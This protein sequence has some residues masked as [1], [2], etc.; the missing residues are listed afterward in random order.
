MAPKIRVNLRL[1]TIELVDKIIA[2]FKLKFYYGN[3][4]SGEQAKT[5]SPQ[6]MSV[7][8]KKLLFDIIKWT[9][10]IIVASIV[11]L[12]VQHILTPTPQRI[13]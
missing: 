3:G 10:I 1:L 5:N 2:Y 8:A 4:E 7:E 9:V 13:F 11:Y 6:K 12:I